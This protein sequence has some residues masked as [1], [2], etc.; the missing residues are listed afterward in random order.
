MRRQQSEIVKIFEVGR[1]IW[2]I[3]EPGSRGGSTRYTFFRYA[4]GSYGHQISI[5]IRTKIG[6]GGERSDS[7]TDVLVTEGEHAWM[8]FG[9][10]LFKADATGLLWL[11]ESGSQR[12]LFE[13]TAERQMDTSVFEIEPGATAITD[14]YRD[15]DNRLWVHFEN[16]KV[17][18]YPKS[19]DRVASTTRPIKPDELD[20][21]AN[22][23]L[24]IYASAQMV[25][26]CGDGSVDILEQHRNG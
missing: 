15:S 20:L 22:E 25:F 12:I 16:G 8:A 23:T 11:T 17:K 24:E 13:K 4:N 21:K 14:L 7:N 3:N 1:D 6:P 5:S 18:R 26:Q 10:H 9:G 19:I 2:F